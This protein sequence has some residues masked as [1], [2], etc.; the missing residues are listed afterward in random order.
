M[1]ETAAPGQE[2]TGMLPGLP[3]ESIDECLRIAKKS[4]DNALK[5]SDGATGAN[6]HGRVL[7]G[8]SWDF[9]PGYCRSAYRDLP[10]PG[11][12]LSNV[13]LRVVCLPQGCSS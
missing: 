5:Q 2:F 12:V 3:H 10:Q 4:I 11:D 1:Y 8:G 6:D 9:H 7:R 13:G